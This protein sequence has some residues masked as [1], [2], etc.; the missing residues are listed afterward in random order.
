MS[1]IRTATRQSPTRRAARPA[2]SVSAAALMACGAHVAAASTSA[3]GTSAPTAATATFRSG[4]WPT[5]DFNA[6]RTGVGPADTG[7][8]AANAGR[9]SLRRV[10]LDG[11]VDSSAI[12]LHALRV[13]GRARDVIFVTTTY[14]KTIAIDAATG[15]KLWEFVPRGIGRYQGTAQITTASPVAD[16]NR[17]FIYAASAD[18]VI[19]KLAAASGRQVWARRVTFDARHEKLASA[20]NLSGRRVIVVTG[21]YIGDIPPYDGHVVT[22]D[23][24][25][26]RIGH[27]WNTECANRQ[28]RRARARRPKQ[29]GTRQSGH[30]PEPSSS[31]GAHGFSWPPVTGRSTAR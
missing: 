27:V 12:E 29:T 18:G 11:T 22:I 2:L 8:T 25:S 6:A 5:F 31:P 13:H 7:I 1:L 19:H 14:G 10:K 9:L 24:T 20:L 28:S 3:A 17:G 15:G 23:R 21:G 26:G 16:P 30:A 4:D